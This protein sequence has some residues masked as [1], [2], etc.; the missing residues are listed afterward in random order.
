MADPR[1][2]S[3]RHRTQVRSVGRSACDVERGSIGGGGGGGGGGVCG[4][5]H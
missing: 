4:S 3:W 1:A 2:K 5:N